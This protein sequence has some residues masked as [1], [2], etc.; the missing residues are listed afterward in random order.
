MHDFS[1]PYKRDEFCN[2][3]KKL[4][5]EDFAIEEIEFKDDTKNELTNKIYKIGEI[6][7]LNHLQ[8]FEIEHSSI[9]DPRVT[10]TKKV[11][12]IFKKLSIEKALIIFYTKNSQNYRFSLIESNYKWLSDT[13]VTREFSM[14]KRLSFLLGP[15]SKIHTPS[16]QFQTKIKN[17][18][19]L[20]NRFDIEVISEEFFQKYKDLF[21][22]ITEHLNKDKKFKIFLEEKKI[23][24]DLFAKKFLGQIVFCYFLQK[25]GCLGAKKNQILSNG[26]K[27]FLRNSFELFNKNKKNFYNDFFEYLIYEGLN[28][29]NKNNFV[30][31][32]DCKIPYLNGGL[33]EEID[34]YDWK[35]EKL[36]I[37]NSFFSNKSGD[38]ILD[39]F[40]LYNFT[41]DENDGLDVEIGID[42]EMLGKV[43]EKLLPE[44]FKKGKGSF[45][46]PRFVVSFMSKQIIKNFLISKQEL[47][48]CDNFIY[49]LVNFDFLDEESILIK[50]KN[51]NN[52]K[53]L[54]IIEGY[55][56][57]I[58]I[59]DPAIGSGAFPV[60]IMNEVTKIRSRILNFLKRDYDIYS[61]KRDF[62]ENSIYGVDID[63]G[64]V[65]ISK[66]RLWLSLIVEERN[67][68]NFQPLPNLSYKI[69]QGNSLIQKFKNYDFDDEKNTND[70]LFEDNETNQIKKELINIQRKYF[71]LSSRKK[72]KELR[73][74]LDQ[75]I[76]KLIFKKINDIKDK[77]IFSN[78]VERNFFLWK[79]F[80]LD[81]FENGG[82]DIVIG[83]PPYV[84]A[85]SSKLK[86]FKENDKEYFVK[87]YAL[88]QYQLNTYSL[89]VELGSNLLKDGGFLSYII[90]H[91][92]MTINT[93]DQFR[94][95]ILSN[96]RIEIINFSKQVFKSAA[97]DACVLNFCKN[98]KDEDSKIT[99]YHE[100]NEIIN[101]RYSNKTKILNDINYDYII[102]FD[103][104]GDPK[105][106]EINNKIIKNSKTLYPHFGIVKSGIKAYEKGKG[107]P[108]QTQQMIDDRVYHTDIKRDE[109]Y[110]KYIEG[111]DVNRYHIDWSKKYI[112]YGKNLA[113]P[114]SSNLFSGSRILVRQ[115]PSKPP[116]CIYATYVTSQYINDMNSKIITDLKIDHKI[117]LAI[118]NSKLISFWFLIRFAKLQRDIFPVFTLNDLEKFPIIDI[119]NKKLDKD[120]ISLIDQVIK[121]PEDNALNDKID[122]LIYDLFLISSEE[123][124]YI[125]NYLNKF[126]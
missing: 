21:F 22:K 17:Y 38:G 70:S 106:K 20:K 83:N 43:F 37:P 39:V 95:F 32:L 40:D 24:I 19:D 101:K 90:P 123:K 120:L 79:I 114:R 41:V 113:A 27:F 103:I 117:I 10:L 45:Y 25:K 63:K 15:G 115:I 77:N 100:E 68:N 60:L 18:D 89:F 82:F 86:N 93:N 122:N 97:V 61:L 59:C 67:I 49:D 8:I 116:Y 105:L 51:F 46:T 36:N 57:N 1:L 99:I 11:F 78:K 4:L 124:I 111:N 112:R 55:L 30:E 66:L 58:K 2:F 12:S 6:K 71:N 9:N 53:L 44:N 91:N 23:E 26:D 76:E 73:I 75:A 29:E 88:A 50:I 80:F 33:F 48:D 104:I 98:Q 92:W 94:K 56:N 96:S 7:S 16:S 81:V 119:N 62:I 107:E 87:K 31:I 84:F 126:N 47:K 13:V 125:E 34:N 69:L 42:P 5:P 110:F 3:L 121:K 74:L 64:A 14:P 28:K 102:N 35:K 54:H 85:R 65:E 118:L 109:N 52:D 72:K 108:P